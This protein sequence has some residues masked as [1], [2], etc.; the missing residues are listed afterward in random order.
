MTRI[1]QLE[2]KVKRLEQKICCKTQFI[3]ELPEEGNEG[4]L[5]ILPDGSVWVWDGLTFV[6]TSTTESYYSNSYVERL[7]ALGSDVQYSNYL[8][9]SISSFNMADGTIYLSSIF[10]PKT[11][12]I[13]N[14]GWRGGSTTGD[15]TA[16][17]YNG[18]GLYSINKITGDLILLGKTANDGSIWAI[19]TITYNSKNFETPLTL[20]KD[21]YFLGFLYNSSAQVTVP[22]VGTNSILGIPGF[23]NIPTFNLPTNTFLQGVVASQT[24]LP[25]SILTAAITKTGLSAVE[26]VI[27]LS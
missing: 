24:V 14:I 18:I 11:T 6:S 8:G 21:I 17:N 27:Y 22:S 10:I 9:G 25:L 7:K 19:P 23:T 15:Y 12:I 13:S 16:D 20:T 26:P 5:Y 4:S 2:Q 1:E 3:D